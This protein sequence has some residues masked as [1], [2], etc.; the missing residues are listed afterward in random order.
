MNALDLNNCDIGKYKFSLPH[1][2]VYLS[3]H[4]VR[5]D[6]LRKFSIYLGGKIAKT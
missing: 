2:D 3:R 4:C 1:K 5:E 6:G